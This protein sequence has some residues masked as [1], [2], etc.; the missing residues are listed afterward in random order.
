MK[1]A[2]YSAAT[3]EH[4]GGAEQ[5]TMQ[6]AFE[7]VTRYQDLSIDIITNDDRFS[8]RL[9]HLLKIYYLQAS[10]FGLDSD[11][12]GSITNRLGD[13]VKYRKARSLRQ[14][15]GWLKEYDLIYSKNEILEALILRLFRLS[16]LPPV[17]FACHTAIEYPLP[18]TFHEKL[19]N[20]LYTGSIYH[21]LCRRIT[22]FHV[23]N[24]TD[25]GN[26]RRSFENVHLI[27]HAFDGPRYL[28]MAKTDQLSKVS[29]DSKV[30]NIAWVGR[31]DDQK[32]VSELMELI[33]L[34]QIRKSNPLRLV[35]N[36]FGDGSRRNDVISYS[37]GNSDVLFHGYVPRSMLAEALE[38]C[39][40][41]ISTS[42]WEALPITIL[43]AITLGLPVVAFDIPGPKDIIIH[44]YNGF[45]VRTLEEFL[46]MIYYLAAGGKVSHPGGG[47]ENFDPDVNYAR[48]VRLFSQYAGK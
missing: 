4:G 27:P 45:I 25:E 43:E 46:D 42:R 13:R 21:L 7:L 29:I 33:D 28:S 15:K 19:H 2:F 38:E 18:K 3:L 5:Y 24:G 41:L 11:S 20:R 22:A 30:F 40:L 48:L 31:L 32:G 1:I 8:K 39:N 6:T 37:N 44:G 12:S 10:R 9:N 14:L 47:M 16:S 36:I 26:L 34:H 23:L 17:V 35:W